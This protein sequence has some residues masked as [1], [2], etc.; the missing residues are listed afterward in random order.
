MKSFIVGDWAVEIS[1]NRISTAGE[2]VELEPR[3]MDLLVLLATRAGEVISKPEIG[4]A[5]WDEVSVN[6]EALT[7]CVFKLRK[8]L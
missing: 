4:Q 6:E 7:R 2:I 1:T 5:L 8:A 3:V